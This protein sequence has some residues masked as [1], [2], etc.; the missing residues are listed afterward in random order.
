MATLIELL[1][2]IFSLVFFHN[3]D[4]RGFNYNFQIFQVSFEKSYLCRD[5]VDGH[6]IS[7]LS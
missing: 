2:N 1:P 4:N 6:G 3:H 7:V 5:R